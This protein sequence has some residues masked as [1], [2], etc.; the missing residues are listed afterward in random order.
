M[1]V[2][3]KTVPLHVM[4][5]STSVHSHH[6]GIF[7]IILGVTVFLLGWT[8]FYPKFSSFQFLQHFNT[9]FDSFLEKSALQ[10]KF[11]RFVCLKLIMLI[12]GWIW[13]ST[14][15]GFFFIKWIWIFQVF[16]K[17]SE[18]TPRLHVPGNAIEIVQ[19]HSGSQSF[20]SNH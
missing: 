15:N 16:S 7:V 14:F 17:S 9:F 18:G 10:V 12:F 3:N 11:L 20:V 6:S 8:S 4:V 19:I 2:L 5:A 1:I 13:N